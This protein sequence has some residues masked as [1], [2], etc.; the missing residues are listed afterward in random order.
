MRTLMITEQ[1]EELLKQNSRQKMAADPL[2][3][4]TSSVD[5]FL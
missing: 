1:L 3:P 5:I 4:A 2:G